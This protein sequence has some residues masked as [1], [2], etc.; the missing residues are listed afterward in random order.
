MIRTD[1][2]CER[3]R[4]LAAIGKASHQGN[5]SQRF[6]EG[7]S[8]RQ[9]VDWVSVQEKERRD[10][11]ALQFLR[12]RLQFAIVSGL[13]LRS[14]IQIESRSVIAQQ[15]IDAIDQNLCTEFLRTRDNQAVPA[16]LPE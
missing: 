7:G 11:A 12:Q 15:M 6:P 5:A 10:L 14:G 1:E 3:G 16:G 9:F 13:L 2:V 4:F 8:V